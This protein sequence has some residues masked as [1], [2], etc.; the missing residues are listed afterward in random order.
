[1]F[2]E[3]LAEPL[4]NSSSSGMPFTVS[5]SKIRRPIRPPSFS[6]EPLPCVNCVPE[7]GQIAMSLCQLCTIARRIDRHVQEFAG[8]HNVREQAT[9]EQVQSIR[10]GTE[11]MRLTL[12]ALIAKNGLASGAR[13]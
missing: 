1:M 5:G 7:L 10:Q 11:G 9:I 3:E 4:A 8:R 6:T 2:R 12:R 13:A